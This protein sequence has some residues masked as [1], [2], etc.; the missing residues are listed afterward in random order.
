MANEGGMMRSEAER[1]DVDDSEVKRRGY[2]FRDSW[3]RG[4]AR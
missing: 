3:S 1:G 4:R 2:S